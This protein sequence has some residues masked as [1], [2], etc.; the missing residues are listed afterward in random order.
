MHQ[1][2]GGFLMINRELLTEE[3]LSALREGREQ[4]R[5]EG[6]LRVA[7]KIGDKAAAEMKKIYDLFDE[8]LYIWVASLWDP[9]IGGFYYSQ[10]ARDYEG[11]LPDIE[12]TRQALGY[13]QGVG[14]C[15]SRGGTWV[16]AVTPEM[17]EALLRFAKGLQYEDDGYFYHPQWGKDVAISRRGRDLGWALGLIDELGDKPNYPTPMERAQDKNSVSTLPDY[18]QS[19]ELWLDYLES[20]DLAHKS[21]SIGSNLQAQV[22]QIKGAGKEF[23]DIF[24]D[25]YAR[26]QNPENGLWEEQVNYASVNGLMKV[27]ISYT[28]CGKRINYAERAFE[29]AVA[30]TLSD[31]VPTG[32]T[33]VFNP[34]VCISHLLKNLTAAGET[35][36]V[37][38]LRARLIENA[39]EMIRITREK[40]I[41]YKADDGAYS[42]NRG[43][44]AYRSQGAYVAIKDTCE[45]EING[46]GLATNGTMREICAALGIERVPYYTVQDSELF[47]ELIDPAKGNPKLYAAVSPPPTAKK[48]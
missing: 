12:S 22:P 45:G 7:Q 29:S 15:Q 3:R 16:K 2:H 1:F 14:L 43:R 26:K 41:P 38:Q 21:Y 46:N 20:L 36:K 13:V 34:W 9:E 30:A 17:R 35:E 42:Y 24:F 25:W 18:L 47:L 10:T 39:A 48:P 37:A 8:E 31:E 28:A 27:A 44:N 11:F 40:L 23:V 19:T 6:F 5:R 32:V 4:M 33:S